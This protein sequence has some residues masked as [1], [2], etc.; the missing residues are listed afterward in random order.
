MGTLP[1]A[2][3]SLLSSLYSL[4]TLLVNLVKLGVDLSN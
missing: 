2:K 1:V 3:L 4:A